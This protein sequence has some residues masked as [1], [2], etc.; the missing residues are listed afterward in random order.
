MLSHV[1]GKRGLVGELSIAH[2][3]LDLILAREPD[4]REVHQLVALKPANAVLGI[5]C[6][7]EVELVSV[8][9][10]GTQRKV[11]GSFPIAASQRSD[12]GLELRGVVHA[13]DLQGDA[14]GI[15]VK[16]AV[17]GHDHEEIGAVEVLSRCVLVFWA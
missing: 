15:A 17:V 7:L 2:F 4:F 3:H 1:Q 13:F 5:A 10:R 11:Q 9:V 6:Q 8:D 12:H 16:L 14:S